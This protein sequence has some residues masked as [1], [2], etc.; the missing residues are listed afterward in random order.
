MGKYHKVKTFFY[1]DARRTNDKG[2]QQIYL[3]IRVDQTKAL[4]YVNRLVNPKIWDKVRQEH[5]GRGLE[6]DTLNV[7]LRKIK[8]DI[9][10]HANTFNLQ[11][12]PFDAADLKNAYSGKEDPKTSLL[13]LI[14][15][16]LRR[17]RD[18]IG[19]QSGI[20]QNSYNSVSALCGK[21]RDFINSHPD[22]KT[23]TYRLKDIS[24]KL[25][26]EFFEYMTVTLNNKYNTAVKGIKV[27]KQ[28]INFGVSIEW[29]DSN[30]LRSF[31]KGYV[32]D[33][34]RYLTKEELLQ[35][36]I[37][38]FKN[39]RVAAI[40]DCFLFCCYTGLSFSDAKKLSKKDIVI[41]EGRPFIDLQRVKTDVGA[42]I[43]LTP[44]A[45]SLLNKYENHPKCVASELLIPLVSN[46]KT[47]LYLKEIAALSGINKELTYH[48]SRHTFATTVCIS[49]G[50][51]YEAV[52]KM[53]GH[54][55]TGTVTARYARVTPERLILEMDKVSEK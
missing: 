24:P 10:N 23:S 13:N 51:S 20:K 5:R 15:E 45:I 25:A 17:Q 52:S 47:N 46:Q 6:A 32:F 9:D 14:D 53:L 27:L 39:E 55:S 50:I 26:Y 44:K 38:G 4:L 1:L 8:L 31:Q 16:F 28:I 35:I 42:L 43:P 34:V 36:E 40:R 18:K 19:K 33:D 22:Y 7:Y 11:G 3:K 29:L 30:P 21:L 41:R 12:D 49:N 37:K 48:M 2:E 54:K